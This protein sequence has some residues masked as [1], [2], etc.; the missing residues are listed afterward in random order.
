MKQLILVLFCCLF[1]AACVNWDITGPAGPEGPPGPPGQKPPG[2]D[3]SSIV[4]RVFTFD[5]FTVPMWPVD[6]VK[7]TL[8]LGAD[9]TLETM[10]DT[11]GYYQFN[12]IGT[13][14]YNLTFSRNGFGEMKVFGQT[15]ISGGTL[16]T[17]VQDVSIVQLPVQTIADS[18]WFYTGAPGYFSVRYS[19][20]PAA[21]IL[22]SR[23]Y[24]VYFSHHANVSSTNY[25][26][27]TEF[28]YH[29]P[30]GLLGHYFTPGDSIYAR[31]Y[32]LT[33]YFYTPVIGWSNN[34]RPGITYVDP[35]S[36]KVVYPFRSSQGTLAA[37]VFVNN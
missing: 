35:A 24:E 4:G 17:T 22:T 6:S 8:H 2:A 20:P 36:G 1:L 5:Q 9:S 31:V 30:T 11:A 3:T 29:M 28:I 14:T 32:T 10:A 21:I 34:I 19:V 23:N 33:K 12:G 7:I 16:N 37:G 18:A 15:H 13:G 27:S 25:E 26:Y